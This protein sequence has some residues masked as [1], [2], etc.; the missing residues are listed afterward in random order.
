VVNPFLE[1]MYVTLQ[2]HVPAS[3]RN[4]TIKYN[5]IVRLTAFTSHIAGS[6]KDVRPGLQGSEILERKQL[7]DWILQTRLRTTRYLGRRSKVI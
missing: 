3:S 4:I 1:F 7:T 2:P 6:G 5:T